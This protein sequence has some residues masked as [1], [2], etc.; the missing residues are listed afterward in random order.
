MNTDHLWNKALLLAVITVLYNI[1]EGLVSVYFGASDETLSLFGFGLDS[2][3]E[4]ISGLGV[5]HMI[6]RIKK[7]NEMSDSF[8][9]L[10]LKITALS[11]YILTFG[12]VLTAAYNIYINNS[13]S[14]TLWGIIISSISIVAMILL[15]RAKVSVGK[16]LNSDAIIADAGCTRTCVY[17]S[18]VL[19]VSSILFEIFRI[20]YIDSIGALGIA[21]YSFKEGNESWGKAAGKRCC[22]SD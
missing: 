21:Y 5:W 16:K 20:G 4:V 8:E 17:L 9:R 2:F 18:I 7:N 1:L 22:C 14:T 13:P 15:I 6:M 10:A 3:A 19:L 11:F 12:I